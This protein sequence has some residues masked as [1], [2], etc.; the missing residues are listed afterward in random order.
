MIFTILKGCHRARPLRL[1]CWWNRRLFNW[2]VQ[3][4]ESCRY[5]LQSEDQYDTNK[6]CGIGYLPGHHRHS[7]R[8]GWRY[9]NEKCWIELSAYCYV[10]GRRIIQHIGFLEIGK[11]Y[12]I[13]LQVT[14]RSY[15]F[16]AEELGKCKMLGNV[17]ID[18]NHNKKFA[19]RLGPFFG[20]NRRAP[21]DIIIQ[22]NKA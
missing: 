18:H 17:V 9:W 22:L 3:F 21:A 7:A 10:D 5:N 1:W 19:Y 11:Q 4:T 20:G 8:F 15:V 14:R 12:R 13:T 6:L 2:Q 16:G